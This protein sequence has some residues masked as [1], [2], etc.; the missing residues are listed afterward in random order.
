MVVHY[1][2]LRRGIFL[3]LH[4]TFRH[5]ATRSNAQT[6]PKLGLPY[7][8]VTKPI[9]HFFGLQKLQPR[10]KRYPALR[11]TSECTLVNPNQVNITSPMGMCVSHPCNLRLKRDWT[12]VENMNFRMCHCFFHDFAAMEVFFSWSWWTSCCYTWAAPAEDDKDM[13]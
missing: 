2:N 3:L 10:I 12:N 4:S 6:P 5:Q 8:M 11:Q 13:I 7:L 9:A 1:I